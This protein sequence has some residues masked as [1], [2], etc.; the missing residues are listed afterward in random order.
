MIDQYIRQNALQKTWE[1]RNEP[2]PLTNKSEFS[3][4]RGWQIEAFNELKDA[5]RMILNAPMGSGK[6]WMMCLLSAYKMNGLVAQ[7]KI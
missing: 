1:R 2:Q 6:S 5:P 3:S 7:P 4:M